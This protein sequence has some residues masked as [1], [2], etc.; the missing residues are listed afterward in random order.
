MFLDA[1]LRNS[2]TS[3]KILMALKTAGMTHCDVAC[4]WN[5][6]SRNVRGTPVNHFEWHLSADCPKA[7]VE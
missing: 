3:L 4:R 2:R 6:R 5:I 7:I 1:V